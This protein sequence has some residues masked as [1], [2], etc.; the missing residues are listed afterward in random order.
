MDKYPPW[1][2]KQEAAAEGSAAALSAA[3]L[4]RYRQ[5]YGYIRS[6]CAA[7]DSEPGNTA[8]IMALLQEVRALSR[9]SLGGGPNT[10]VAADREGGRGQLCARA[11]RCGVAPCLAQAVCVSALTLCQAVGCFTPGG[12]GTQLPAGQRLPSA[13]HP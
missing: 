10:C 5:Q 6:L 8:K 12:S 13:C 7:Y 9:E 3:E 1:L 4:G 11:R 2:A